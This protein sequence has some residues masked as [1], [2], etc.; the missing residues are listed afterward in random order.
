MPLYDV[1]LGD[2]ELAQNVVQTLTIVGPLGG[3]I[4][5]DHIVGRAAVSHEQKLAPVLELQIGNLIFVL[6]VLA[7]LD[8]EAK[9]PRQCFEILTQTNYRNKADIVGYGFIGLREH[10]ATPSRRS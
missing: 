5:I 2:A 7:V 8:G 1:R 9:V 10:V 6:V 4:D 3:N